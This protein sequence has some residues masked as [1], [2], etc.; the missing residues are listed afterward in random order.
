MRAVM[1]VMLNVATVFAG[2]LKC[3][4]S[5]LLDGATVFVKFGGSK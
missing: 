2:S 4:L 5:H 3:Q 1:Y